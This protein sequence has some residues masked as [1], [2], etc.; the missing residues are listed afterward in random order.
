[1]AAPWPIVALALSRNAKAKE[2]CSAG[3]MQQA[4]SVF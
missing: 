2:A 4:T 1:M 3:A